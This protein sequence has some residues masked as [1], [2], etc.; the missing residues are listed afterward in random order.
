MCPI[1][2]GVSFTWVLFLLVGF[3]GNSID[4]MIPS[5][6]IGGS[7]VGGSYLLEKKVALA[8][9]SFLLGKTLFITAG[10]LVTERL[11]KGSW[12]IAGLGI[13][14]ILAIS[15]YYLLSFGKSATHE[16]KQNIDKIKK[17]LNNCC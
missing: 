13:L 14:F 7:V 6:L 3:T 4:W 2:V 17:Q 9:Q 10:F 5:I 11:I 1:C 16:Q 8:G 12:L 15:A